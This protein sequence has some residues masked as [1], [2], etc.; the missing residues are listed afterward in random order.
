MANSKW[1]ATC[2]W[3]G[4]QGNATKSAMPSPPTSSPIVTGKCRSHP[5]GKSDA[6][7]GPRWVAIPVGENQQN[8]RWEAVC[9]W[10]GRTGNSTKSSLPSPPTSNPIITGKCNSHPS[11]NPDANHGPR[12]E[13]R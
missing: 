1:I 10:C 2:Q 3:C 5:S 9:Q 7:H 4:Q 8:S 13:R 6:N 11:G 12:W